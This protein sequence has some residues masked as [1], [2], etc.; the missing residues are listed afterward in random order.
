MVPVPGSQG[1]NSLSSF[2]PILAFRKNRHFE[3]Y[4][5]LQLESPLLSM[6][7]KLCKNKAQQQ[8]SGEKLSCSAAGG[9]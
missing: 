8:S 3:L 5:L 2:F 1:L 9:M 6:P 7:G 4:E